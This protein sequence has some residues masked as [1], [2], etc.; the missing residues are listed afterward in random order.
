[1]SE[2]HTPDDLLTSA[3]EAAAL[4]GWMVKVLDGEEVSEFAESFEPVKRVAE[5]IARNNG[6]EKGSA[7]LFGALEQRNAT[8][9]A[10]RATIAALRETN[11]RLNRR[12]TKAEG[13]VLSKAR[14][15]SAAGRN[16]G[17]ALAN[18]ACSALRAQNAELLAALERARQ[19]FA[20]YA[21][22]HW[23]KDTQLGRNK[24]L[25][26]EVEASACSAAIAN[27]KESR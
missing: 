6:L 26:N 3:I 11:A 19:K 5:L 10:D 18:A 17:R 27:A 20:D 24:A 16:L 14:H 21:A 23:A 25:E 7:E 2:T 1:M 12:A 13:V 15:E 9:E 22:I 8:I 4:A